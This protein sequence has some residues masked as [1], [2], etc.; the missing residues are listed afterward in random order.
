M[1]LAPTFS[2]KREIIIPQ[3]QMA[4][5]II[6]DNQSHKH[7]GVILQSSGRWTEHITDIIQR[8]KK[9]VDILRGLMHRLDRRTL[10]IMYLTYIKPLLEFSNALLDNCTKGEKEKLEEIQLAAAR[11]VSGGTRGTNHDLLY[12]EVA[13][14]RG[15]KENTEI[16]TAAQDALPQKMAKLA[17]IAAT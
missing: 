3:I 14:S 7:L 16:K 2:R 10:E 12:N 5:E 11:V 8:A 15:K 9:K 1:Q 4:N 13:K 6:T 17:K